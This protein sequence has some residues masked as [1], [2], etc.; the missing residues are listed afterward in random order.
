M[1]FIKENIGKIVGLIL[2]VVLVVIS[3]AYGGQIIDKIKS[4]ADSGMAAIDSAG[5][6]EF[7]PYNG[8]NVSG[9]DVITTAKRY[10]ASVDVGVVIK[11]N[12]SAG[13][14][15]VLNTTGASPYFTPGATPGSA[16]AGTATSPTTVSPLMMDQV[17][18]PNYVNRSA[19]FAA[20]I[21]TDTAGKIQLISFV[22][23]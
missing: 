2:V 14:F 4:G 8:R 22:E 1:D 9:S 21:Y 12:K 7:K 23:K 18:S 5:S 10:A 16:T 11:T 13:T 3:V 15:Y 20:N 17:T 19:T 6:E